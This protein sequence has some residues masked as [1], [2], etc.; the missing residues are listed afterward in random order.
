MLVNAS[1]WQNYSIELCC[2]KGRSYTG[3]NRRNKPCRTPVSATVQCKPQQLRETV[4][5]TYLESDRRLY[6]DT[7]SASSRI[8]S[9]SGR[10]GLRG[11]TLLQLTSKRWRDYGSLTCCA[12]FSFLEV[13]GEI[14]LCYDLIVMTFVGVDRCLRSL[15]LI[16]VYRE[17]VFA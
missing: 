2:R 16:G 6:I 9:R 15:A 14:R 17:T 11:W 5:E 8:G 10:S 1:L 12:I 3:Y 13:V 7:D 4:T